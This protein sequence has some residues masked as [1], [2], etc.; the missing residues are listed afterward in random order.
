MIKG[1]IDVTEETG[2]EDSNPVLK[3]YAKGEVINPNDI[4][5]LSQPAK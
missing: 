2:A 3:S 1:K 4:Q 5:A